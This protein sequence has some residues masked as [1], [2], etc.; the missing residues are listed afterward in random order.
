MPVSHKSIEKIEFIKDDGPEQGI[1]HVVMNKE[2]IPKIL[3][4][5][6]INQMWNVEH[7]YGGLTKR[8]YHCITEIK[9]KIEEMKMS[10][11]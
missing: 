10:C 5:F 1:S 7:I 8:G 4:K 6:Y 9:A 11:D 3:D 2:Y